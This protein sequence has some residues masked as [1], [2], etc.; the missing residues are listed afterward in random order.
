MGISQGQHDTVIVLR[1]LQWTVPLRH[2]LLCM[3]SVDKGEYQRIYCGL[4]DGNLSIIDV[5]RIRFV[6]SQSMLCFVCSIALRSTRTER[7]LL[8]VD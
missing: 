6:Y 8:R 4:S 2:C 7:S 5:I 3:T 1:K